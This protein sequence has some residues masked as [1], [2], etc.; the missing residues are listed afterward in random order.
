[1][2]LFMEGVHGF[3]L[4]AWLHYMTLSCLVLNAYKTLHHWVSLNV[5]SE[6]RENTILGLLILDFIR[7]ADAIIFTK[8]LHCRET[9]SLTRSSATDSARFNVIFQAKHVHVCYVFVF[10]SLIKNGGSFCTLHFTACFQVQVLAL[11]AGQPYDTEL[12]DL[13]NLDAHLTNTCRLGEGEVEEEQAVRL[14]SELPQVSKHR[15]TCS[16]P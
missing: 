5:F 15:I 3:C 11:F 6:P 14:L 4:T 12:Q 10:G 2:V 8:S 13:G 1:M 9:D 7:P 16:H